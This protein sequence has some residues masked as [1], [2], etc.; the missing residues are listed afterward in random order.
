MRIR[1]AK[2]MEKYIFIEPINLGGNKNGERKT[3]TDK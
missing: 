3:G 1:Y 2:C